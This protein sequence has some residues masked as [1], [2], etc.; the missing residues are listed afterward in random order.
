[1]SESDESSN[2]GYELLEETDELA[3]TGPGGVFVEDDDWDYIPGGDESLERYYNLKNKVVDMGYLAY[4]G[5]NMYFYVDAS[6]QWS[7]LMSRDSLAR[8]CGVLGTK[9]VSVS[10]AE[11]VEHYYPWLAKRA[12]VNAALPLQRSMCIGT[13]RIEVALEG[14]GVIFSKGRRIA[15]VPEHADQRAAEMCISPIMSTKLPMA[16]R[17]P[18]GGAIYNHIAPLFID[19]RDMLTL[20]WHIGNCIIDPM[21]TPRSL[22]LAGPGGSGKST[23]LNTI[24]NVLQGCSGALPD[25]TFTAHHASVS[26]KV[27]KQLLASR[28]VTCGDVDLEKHTMDM[29]AVRTIV[30]SDYITLGP[31]RSLIKCSLTLATNGLMDPKMDYV[32]ASDSIIRRMIVVYMDAKASSL[33]NDEIPQSQEARG[34][35]ACACAYIRLKYAHVPVTPRTV[36]LTLMGARYLEIQHMIEEV[37]EPT[38]TD[39]I[40]VLTIIQAAVGIP[41][42][43]IGHKASLI[44]RDAVISMGERRFLRGLRPVPGALKNEPK[45]LKKGDSKKGE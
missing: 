44:S 21:Q 9:N 45:P 43:D 17:W 8:I 34:D 15:E 4:S 25:G 29:H 23:I 33:E 5:G 7:L 42:A 40:D 22:M 18:G 32:A 41:Y 16:W 30:S 38:L 35:F 13:R 24:V 11:T 12:I 20:M 28:M 31:Y 3:L 26:E 27:L 37:D 14:D 36:L 2:V 6:R 1:M 39:Y 19:S 10:T